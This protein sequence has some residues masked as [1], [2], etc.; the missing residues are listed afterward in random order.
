MTSLNSARLVSMG[1]PQLRL[2]FEPAYHGKA[3]GEDLQ[4]DA[5]AIQHPEPLLHIP[6]NVDVGCALRL[7]KGAD[8]DGIQTPPFGT[9]RD[10][11]VCLPELLGGKVRE[12]VDAHIRSPLSQKR[13][14][15]KL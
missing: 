13:F 10:R 7:Y 2:R 8:G 6:E 4:V 9:E 5:V 1:H 15:L 11:Q 14:R 3:E 12:E